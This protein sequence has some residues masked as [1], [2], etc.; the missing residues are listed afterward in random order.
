MPLFVKVIP[1]RAS[2]SEVAGE[3]RLLCCRPRWNQTLSC[4][5]SPNGWASLMRQCGRPPNTTSVWASAGSSPAPPATG[6]QA[7]AEFADVPFI[8]T[9]AAIFA[10]P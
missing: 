8:E 10:A 3:P 6:P 7:A 2:T 5:S 4:R 1:L 9:F